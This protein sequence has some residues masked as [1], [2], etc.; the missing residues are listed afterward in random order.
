[1]RTSAALLE[2]N[3]RYG[4]L[5]KGVFCVTN[6]GRMPCADYTDA[7]LQNAFF[8]GYTTR[9]RGYESVRLELLR[10]AH[11]CICQ[12]PWQLARKQTSRCLWSLLCQAQRRGDSPWVCILGNSAFVNNRSATNGKL[13]RSRKAN[14]SS[15]VPEAAALAA[16]DFVLQRAM[17]TERQAAEW[18]VRV[19]KGPFPRL[20][21]PLPANARERLRL[22][23]I[24]CHLYNFR[25][26][27][28]G[29]NQ[30]RTT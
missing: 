13:L 5:L 8:E 20:K 11:S 15:D 17:P 18:G 1:M 26:R 23:R 12:L 14:K 22:I 3:R 10:R 27:F 9:S 25:V 28:I 29:I 24:C 16:V 30:I 19:M 2:S 4:P 7:D 21:T 6:G